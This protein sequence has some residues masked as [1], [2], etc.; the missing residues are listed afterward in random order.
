MNTDKQVQPSVRPT[1]AIFHGLY[2]AYSS[3]TPKY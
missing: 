1:K 2:T 3:M